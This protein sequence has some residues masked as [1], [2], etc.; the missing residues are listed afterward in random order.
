MICKSIASVF[1]HDNYIMYCNMCQYYQNF[2]DTVGPVVTLS[3]LTSHQVLEAAG[4]GR[5]HIFFMIVLGMMSFA[6]AAEIFMG[7]S[8]NKNIL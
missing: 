7:K 5:Y 1:D 2:E 8:P 3:N 6:D 4:F